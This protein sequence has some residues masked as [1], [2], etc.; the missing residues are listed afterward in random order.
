MGDLLCTECSEKLD[1]EVQFICDYCGQTSTTCQCNDDASAPDK[2]FV[3][4][5]CGKKHEDDI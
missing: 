5:W 4:C 1:Q 2:V 3:C